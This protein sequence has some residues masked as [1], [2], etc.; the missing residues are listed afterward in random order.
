MSKSNKL[1]RG[2]DSLVPEEIDLE[3]VVSD[4]AQKVHLI[5]IKSIIPNKYQPRKSFN[6]EELSQLA[7]SIKERGVLQ[8]IIVTIEEGDQYMLIAGE[9]R[10]RAASEVGLDKIPAIIKEVDKLNNLQIAILENVQRSDLNALELSQA[11]NRLHHEFKQSYEDIAQQL[12][13][14]YTTILNSARL[15]Q[16][17][18]YIQKA[19]S[20]G[21]ISEGHARSL[22]AVNDQP[23]V[24]KSL[25][26]KILKERISVRQ[27]ESLVN[28]AKEKLSKKPKEKQKLSNKISVGSLVSIQ[29]KLKAKDV[30]I[31]SLSN[32]HQLIISFDDLDDLKRATDRISR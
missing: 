28:Q 30:T 4:S 12:G 23:D 1:G 11:I 15:I 13:K 14:A 9:R 3:L 21:L 32:Q 8:P 2:L 19:L 26:N 22:L 29:K 5:D 10:W 24:Q 31:K 17:P 18:E 16:L 6:S 25:F 27:I 20:D 7:T